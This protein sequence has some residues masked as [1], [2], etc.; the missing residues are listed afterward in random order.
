VFDLVSA[1]DDFQVAP[2]KGADP[3]FGYHHF[4]RPRSNGRINLDRFLNAGKAR[5]LQRAK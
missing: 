4:A 2:G 3:A 1:K 5:A